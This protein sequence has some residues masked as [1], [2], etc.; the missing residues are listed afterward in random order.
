M[1]QPL[2]LAQSSTCLGGKVLPD[3]LP[4]L[5]PPAILGRDRPKQPLEH[6][7]RI[8]PHLLIV[9]QLKHL[10]TG[11]GGLRLH[12]KRGTVTHGAVRLHAERT[13]E[14]EEATGRLRLPIAPRRVELLRRLQP[15]A[16]LSHP[17]AAANQLPQLL[18]ERMPL[19]QALKPRRLLWTRRPEGRVRECHKRLQR[20]LSRRE[21]CLFLEVGV[22]GPHRLPR[23]VESAVESGP[24]ALGRALR[25]RGGRCGGGGGRFACRGNVC[26][27]LA[28]RMHG[29]MKR[30]LGSLQTHVYP[31]EALMTVGVL[32]A[33]LGRQELKGA[34]ALLPARGAHGCLRLAR[35]APNLD[36]EIKRVV[37]R[38]RPEGFV[39]ALL[40]RCELDRRDRRLGLLLRGGVPLRAIGPASPATVHARLSDHKLAGRVV[41][42]R[43]QDHGHCVRDVRSQLLGE[44]CLQLLGDRQAAERVGVL[45][46]FKMQI[47]EQHKRVDTAL[48]AL[49]GQTLR[50][51]MRLEELGARRRARRLQPALEANAAHRIYLIV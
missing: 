34:H 36:D 45:T 4:H 37:H 39:T 25:R 38:A 33:Q 19:A 20:D 12:L 47:R 24:E 3:A 28:D 7:Q 35:L 6:I 41:P 32:A 8:Q 42:K 22:L 51:P 30:R 31:L 23:R 26:E 43:A 44:T 50:K 40:L 5:D 2:E 15:S 48:S 18:H 14:R 13:R 11:F 16:R 49:R 17:C 27:C 9:G 1:T 29:C 10:F 46:P 21:L